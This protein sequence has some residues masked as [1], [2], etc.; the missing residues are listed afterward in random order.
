MREPAVRHKPGAVRSKAKGIIIDTWQSQANLSLFLMLL[1]LTAF[2]LPSLGFGKQDSRLYTNL[3]FTILLFSGIAIAWGQWKLFI[4]SAV[5]GSVALAVRWSAWG[6]GTTRSE[7][8][9]DWWTM[10]AIAVIAIVLLTQI[11]RPGRVTQVRIQ[12]AIAVYLLFGIVWA[13]AYHITAILHPGSFAF[14]AGELSTVADWVY[15]SFVT[16]TTV[17]YG[18]ITPTA[19]ISRTLAVA[20]ALVG[21]LYLAVMLARLVAME[22][23]SWQEKAAGRGAKE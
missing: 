15:Y 12:G 17:G 23:V 16:L 3:A 14:Q 5:V 8:R 22:I 19:Q 7:L 9:S 1:V 4:V 21:Q 10:A 18:D 6:L 13:H 20:E 11:F 2:V